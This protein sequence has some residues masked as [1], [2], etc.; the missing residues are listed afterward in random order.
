MRGSHPCQPEAQVP[1][2]LSRRRG[3]AG[4]GGQVGAAVKI[5]SGGRFSAKERTV[6]HVD[7]SGV[8]RSERSATGTTRFKW[9]PLW[10]TKVVAGTQSCSGP[11]GKTRRRVQTASAISSPPAFTRTGA[12]LDGIGF[13]SACMPES[14]PAAYP[15]GSVS[16]ASSCDREVMLSLR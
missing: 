8:F 14:G 1:P 6:G 13:V 5:F 10:K 4:D 7:I 11:Q 3:D 12:S 16:A 15:V 9:L 2:A